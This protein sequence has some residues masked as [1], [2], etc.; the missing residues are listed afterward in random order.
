MIFMKKILKNFKYN[1]YYP[2]AYGVSLVVPIG[3]VMFDI[4]D[5]VFIYFKIVFVMLVVFL[6]KIFLFADI[7]MINILFLVTITIPI[8][9]LISLYRDEYK[10]WILSEYLIKERVLK[11]YRIDVSHVKNISDS[12]YR[13]LLKLH[14]KFGRY[15]NENML[16]YIK[17]EELIKEYKRYNKK[18]MLIAILVFLLNC[19]IV[20][21]MINY[22]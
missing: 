1:I 10:G 11:F 17:D 16:V 13:E 12:K 4:V 22:S 3:Y 20:Y 9:G 2:L 21:V 14:R 7:V 15:N 5:V 8:I 19:L 18:W 6:F